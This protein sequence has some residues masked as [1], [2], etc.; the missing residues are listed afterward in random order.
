M[1]YNI[2]LLLF[3]IIIFEA[4]PRSAEERDRHPQR[5]TSLSIFISKGMA[6]VHKKLV[7]FQSYFL[8]VLR[9]ASNLSAQFLFVFSI[10]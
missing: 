4:C 6:L 2:N 9:D 7:I 1:L 3:I 5:R 10:L 8:W